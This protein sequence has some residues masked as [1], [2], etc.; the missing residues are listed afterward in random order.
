MLQKQKNAAAVALVTSSFCFMFS[1]LTSCFGIILSKWL[2][3][4]LLTIWLWRILN[5][6]I[7][8]APLFCIAPFFTRRVMPLTAISVMPFLFSE[9]ED[10]PDMPEL[11]D[12]PESIDAPKPMVVHRPCVRLSSTE[13]ELDAAICADRAARALVAS[14]SGVWFLVYMGTYRISGWD[15]YDSFADVLTRPL[16]PSRYGRVRLFMGV[17]RV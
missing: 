3:A 16:H 12:A 11:I 9:D 6:C 14:Y 1:C 10:N 8:T 15:Q 5:T 2:K 4:N 13:A 7:S 17:S